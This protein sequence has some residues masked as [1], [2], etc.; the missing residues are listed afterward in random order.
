M[1]GVLSS[2]SW[3]EKEPMNGAFGFLMKESRSLQEVHVVCNAKAH[4]L[5]RKAKLLAVRLQQ[6]HWM[7]CQMNAKK[8]TLEFITKEGTMCKKCLRSWKV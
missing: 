5:I 6:T 1:P 3:K 4:S 8:L 2:L 7:F